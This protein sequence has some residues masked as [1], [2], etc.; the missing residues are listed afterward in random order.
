MQIFRSIEEITKQK[1]SVLTIG[2]F[3]GVH[4]GHRNI[5]AKLKEYANVNGLRDIVI[6]FEPHPRS[7]VSDYDIKLLSTLDEKIEL[8]ESLDVNNLLILKLW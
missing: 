3:D 1:K 8:L 2:T 4:A 7:V 6:T 5:I